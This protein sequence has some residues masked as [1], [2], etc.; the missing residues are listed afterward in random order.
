MRARSP[1]VADRR[2]E[3]SPSSSRCRAERNADGRELIA[4]DYEAYTDMAA[5]QL[6][7]LAHEAQ[8]VG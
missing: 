2:P 1:I 3:G 4:L 5:R 8:R 6:S 7:Q